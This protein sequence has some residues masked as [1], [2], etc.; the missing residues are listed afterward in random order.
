MDKITI[1]EAHEIMF[2]DYPD[3]VDIKELS[4]MLGIC[5]KKA[6]ELVRD[7]IIPALPCSKCYKIAKIEVINYMLHSS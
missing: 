4:E 5:T 3:V 7:G 1:A 6:R 2:T